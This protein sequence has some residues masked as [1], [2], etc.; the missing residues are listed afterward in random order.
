MIMTFIIVHVLSS[1]LA[2]SRLTFVLAKKRNRNLLGWT[3]LSLI[4]GPLIPLIVSFLKTKEKEETSEVEV[5]GKTQKL[6]NIIVS[7]FNKLSKKLRFNFP[8]I[9]LP[10]KIIRA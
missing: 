1:V 4:F 10:Y 7:N 8:K 6:R 9:S 5:T 3:T 2:F